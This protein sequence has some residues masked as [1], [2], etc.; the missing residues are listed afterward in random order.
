MSAATVIEARSIAN[1]SGVFKDFGSLCLNIKKGD[2][3]GIYGANKNSSK[4]ITQILSAR[5]SSKDN[6]ELFILGLNAHSHI[7]TVKSKVG[8]ATYDQLLDDEFTVYENLIMQASYY[9]I[10]SRESSIYAKELLRS[11]QI[12]ECEDLFPYSLTNEQTQK[13][14]IAKALIHKPEILLLEKVTDHLSEFSL[15]RVWSYLNKKNKEGL[16]IVLITENHQQV[17]TYCSFAVVIAEGDKVSEGVPR[18]LLK[19]HIGEEVL[20]LS[21]AND[22]IG[23]YL[24][25]IKDNYQY[26]I[27]NKRIIVFLK[28]NDHINSVLNLVHCEQ[29][30]IRKPNLHDLY[31]KLSGIKI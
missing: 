31:L 7:Q 15:K 16:T 4:S 1:S 20:E 23:Y 17:E 19:E 24:K 5:K 2:I 18:K 27:S 10:S 25:K 29:I 8:V 28:K 14:L 11:F 22:D 21:T 12:D 6:G 26:Q 9:G 13:L 30:I 3:C